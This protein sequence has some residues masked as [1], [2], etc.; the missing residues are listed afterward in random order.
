MAKESVGGVSFTNDRAQL[1]V[2][3][4]GGREIKVLHL[5]DLKK[6]SDRE[7]W[8]LEAAVEMRDKGF[9]VAGKVKKIS[10]ALDN[11]SVFLHS[12]PLDRTMTAAEQIEHLDWELANYIDNYNTT[13]YVRDWHIL[14]GDGSESVSNILAA[15]VNR[16]MINSL[17]TDLSAR[18]LELHVVDTNHFCALYA[19]ITNYPEVRDKNVVLATVDQDR[20]DAGRIANG[21]L[22]SYQYTLGSRI[23]EAADFIEGFSNRPEITDVFLYGL[24]PT[25]E[26]F[27]KLKRSSRKSITILDPLRRL[28]LASS[29]TGVKSLASQANRFATAIGCALRKE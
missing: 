13:D 6:A 9:K 26:L 28:T 23:E 1:A 3:E 18:G 5:E 22:V 21:W 11:T 10:V 20:I 14:G 12:F 29:V 25:S 8:F 19:L 16:P 2:L 7:T 24:G 27:A 4:V 15:C 17:S